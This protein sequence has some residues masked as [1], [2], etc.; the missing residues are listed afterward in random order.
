MPQ[1]QSPC[2]Q[3]DATAVGPTHNLGQPLLTELETAHAQQRTPKQPKKVLG[4]VT[5]E[6]AI[7][8][9]SAVK[10]QPKNESHKGEKLF[11]LG[12]KERKDVEMSERSHL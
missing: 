8:F 9:P 3:R 1:R 10:I 12:E 4:A 6:M 5:Q 7:C 11:A 2:P